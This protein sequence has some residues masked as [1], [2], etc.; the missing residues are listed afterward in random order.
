MEEKK[1]SGR[2]ESIEVN[3]KSDHGREAN[4]MLLIF[5]LMIAAYVLPLSF[6]VGLTVRPPAILIDSFFGLWRD[7]C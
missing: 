6:V 2:T 3:K 5:V 1:I 7:W 4:G